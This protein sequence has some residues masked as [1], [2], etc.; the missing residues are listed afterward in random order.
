MKNANAVCKSGETGKLL[1]E[2]LPRIVYSYY[3]GFIKGYSC[4][5]GTVILPNDI[6]IFSENLGDVKA[7]VH[8][9]QLG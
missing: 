8:A 4:R 3:R 6:E 2:D 9:L 7:S 1:L 5:R